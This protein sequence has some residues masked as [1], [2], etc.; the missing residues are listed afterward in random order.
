MSDPC[1]KHAVRAVRGRGWLR[2]S[3]TVG[4]ESTGS[5]LVKLLLQEEW[6][7]NRE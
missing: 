2:N 7:E 5:E 1:Q 3:E 4:L 6:L